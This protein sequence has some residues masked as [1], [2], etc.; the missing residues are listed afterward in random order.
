MYQ[1]YAQQGDL[2]EDEGVGG[3]GTVGIN[4]NAE[5]Y[6]DEEENTNPKGAMYPGNKF[7]MLMQSAA[8]RKSGGFERVTLLV[9]SDEDEIM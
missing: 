9:E 1:K 5:T 3:T 7:S 2:S 8:K 6:S 4:K